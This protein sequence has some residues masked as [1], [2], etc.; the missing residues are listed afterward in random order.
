[1]VG[2]PT[3]AC[4]LGSDELLVGYSRGFYKDLGDRHHID[5]DRPEEHWLARSTDGG[6]TWTHEHPGERGQLVPFGKS[7]HGTV[8]PNLKQIPPRPCPGG[9]DFLTPGFALTVRMTD[10]DRGPS[11][12]FYSL[13]RGKEWRGPFSFPDLG[14]QGIAARTDYLIEGR[15]QCL[16]FLT[17]AKTD[18]EE[19]PS[20]LR[21]HS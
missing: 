11:R 3:T 15:N 18:G 21:A 6:V 1:M 10:V 8:P 17:A 5:R 14:T 2:Q 7:L 19:G 9:I 4:G 13:D 12:F 20:S 16:V